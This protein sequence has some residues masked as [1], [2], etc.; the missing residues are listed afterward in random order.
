MSSI[1]SAPNS[2]SMVGTIQRKTMPFTLL[3]ICRFREQISRYFFVPALMYSCPLHTFLPTA[4]HQPI[5]QFPGVGISNFLLV[6][7]DPCIFCNIF[8]SKKL[9]YSSLVYLFSGYSVQ[10]SD[11][12]FLNLKGTGTRDLIWL[13]VVSLDRSWLVQGSRKTFKNF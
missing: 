10:F 2:C 11:Y 9:W 12:L 8:V 1:N 13:K 5:N 3:C 6:N 4:I 7:P